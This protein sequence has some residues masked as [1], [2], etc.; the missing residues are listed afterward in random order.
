[1]QLLTIAWSVI[2]PIFLMMGVGF[3]VQRRLGLDIRS[4]TRLNF[5]VF[6]PALLFIRIVDSRLSAPDMLRIIMHFAILL[7]LMLV[8]AWQTAKLLGAGDRLRRAF[9]STV[10]FYNSANYGVPV[11]Q[12]AFGDLGVAVQAI[13]AM[14]Q[15]ITNF[16]I[17]LALVAG[18]RGQG[19]RHTLKAIFKLPMIYVLVAAWA[20]RATHLPLPLPLNTALHTLSNGLVPVALVTLGAQMATLRSHRFSSAMAG[21][22]CLRLC[23]GPIL[24]YLIVRVLGIHGA[25][26]QSLI[27]STSFPTAVNVALLSMEFDNEPDFAAAAVFYSTLLSAITVSLVIFLVKQM[28][29]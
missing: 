22:L 20:W 27:V 16:T 29:L 4:L 7:T 10:L 28:H 5:W 3:G 25:L 6:I 15:N 23:L 1:M 2:A 11:A 26:A 12:L 17:G 9:T 21:S 19:R 8:I 13:V 24:G 18:G 14:L